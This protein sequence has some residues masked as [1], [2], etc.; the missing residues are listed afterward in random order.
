MTRPVAWIAAGGLMLMAAAGC[1]SVQASRARNQYLTSQLDALRYEKPLEEVWTEVR[2]LLAD[3]GYPLAGVDAE[4][5][6]QRG[7]WLSNVFSPAKETRPRSADVGLFQALSGAGRADD[8][9]GQ[10]LETGWLERSWNRYRVDG[11]K[12][13]PGCRI[14]FTAIAQDVTEHRDAG[15]R[16]DLEMELELARRVDPEAAARIEASIP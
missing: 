2:R 4:A 11:L 10:Y 12:D 8:G 13:G 15:R 14:V 7:G 1:A 9:S 6:G 5:V 16:R 3:R